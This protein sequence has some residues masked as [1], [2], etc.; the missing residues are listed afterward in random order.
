[1]STF[2]IEQGYGVKVDDSVKPQTEHNISELLIYLLFFTKSF[3]PFFVFHLYL[4]AS[5][6][7]FIDDGIL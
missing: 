1:M 2:L 5:S 6:F 3:T 4:F 7:R